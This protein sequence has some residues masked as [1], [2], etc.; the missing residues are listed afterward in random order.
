MPK[1][2]YKASNSLGVMVSGS[3]NSETE[4]GAIAELRMKGYSNIEINKSAFGGFFGDLDAKL[5]KM[6]S[7]TKVSMQETAIVSRQLST[8]VNAGV[9]VLEAVSDVAAMVQ[10]AYFSSVLLK[11]AEDV[12]GG[13]TLSEALSNYKKIFDNTFTSMVAVGEKSGKLAKVL[14]DLAEHLENSVKLRRKI[15]SAMSYPIF[16]GGFFIVV[17]IGIVFILIP[18]FEDMFASFGA[19]LPLPTQMVVNVSHFCVDHVLILILFLI[20]L[21][22]AFK[23][24]TRTPNGLLMWHKFFFK[25]PKFAPIYTKMIFANF[26]QTLSTLIKSGVDIVSSIQI[27]S[28]TL[29][30]TYV[31]LILEDIRESIIAGELFSARM[32][33][34]ELFP[35]MIVRMTAVGEKTGQMD[36]MFDKIT[37]YYNDEV[38]AAV[39]TISAVIEPVLIVGLGFMVGICVI[40][41]YLPIFNMAN[42]MVNQET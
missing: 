36:E 38:D 33:K 17:F 6:T 3:V 32:D 13:S 24:W 8:L 18:K 20:V 27:A 26:F 11:I 7:S 10:N 31:R 42:A 9:N 40:A 21:Y 23:L 29:N 39:A 35:K 28:S 34:Y 15:K 1:F 37:D 22:I 5:Q 19:E 4:N 25:I 12:K 30:N 2:R 41:L 16:V 14:A